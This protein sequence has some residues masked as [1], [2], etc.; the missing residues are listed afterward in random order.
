MEILVELFWSHPTSSL[1]TS[2]WLK[3]QNIHCSG[4]QLICFIAEFP[5]YFPQFIIL[6]LQFTNVHIYSL[7]F[8]SADNLHHLLYIHHILCTF[9]LQLLHYGK[10]SHLS[11]IQLPTMMIGER[12]YSAVAVVGTLYIKYSVCV[13]VISLGST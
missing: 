9:S 10:L 4:R 2:S 13:S 7:S 5:P 8:H 12:C 11:L 3:V 1:V 6:S